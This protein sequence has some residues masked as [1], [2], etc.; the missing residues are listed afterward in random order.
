M[1]DMYYDDDDK[2]IL[3]DKVIIK[4]YHKCDKITGR[5]QK[6]PIGKL[7]DQIQSYHDSKNR[8]G[9]ILRKFQLKDFGVLKY[10]VSLLN[11][12]HYRD[13]GYILDFEYIGDLGNEIIDKEVKFFISILNNFMNGKYET[14]KYF[15]Y[16]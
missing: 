2:I 16:K 14:I 9:I 10:Q 12:M 15:L 7:L 3:Y 6:Y 13:I 1:T 4:I 8:Y 5:Y 11:K